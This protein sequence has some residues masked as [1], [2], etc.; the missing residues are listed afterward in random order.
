MASAVRLSVTPPA[1]GRGSAD[2]AQS[3][4][5]TTSPLP[6]APSLPPG[7]QG[8]ASL[9]EDTAPRPSVAV[10]ELVVLRC[11]P[12]RPSRGITLHFRPR[13]VQGPKAGPAPAPPPAIAAPLRA[14]GHCQY[15]SRC[16]APHSPASGSSRPRSRRTAA[17]GSPGG[18]GTTRRPLGCHLRCSG[19]SRCRAARTRPG[20]LGTRA[21]QGA[22]GSR[23]GPGEPPL[24]VLL[25][26]QARSAPSPGH[27]G[28]GLT[29]DMGPRRGQ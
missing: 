5:A 10:V 4:A 13:L 21:A 25:Q 19:R 24:R 1:P 9:P 22:P 12:R 7:Q 17:P 6:P 28:S 18:T 27:T 23:G 3:T 14:R 8:R 2:P 20:T 29:G 26:P 11:R 15:L 16:W